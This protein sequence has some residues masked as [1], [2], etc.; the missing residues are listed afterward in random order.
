[1]ALNE[2]VRRLEE[3]V[4]SESTKRA[5]HLL[6]HLVDHL[7][8]AE[9]DLHRAAELLYQARDEAGMRVALQIRIDLA[10]LKGRVKGLANELIEEVGGDLRLART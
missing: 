6:L 5:T 8:E 2:E 9:T 3:H 7:N 4:A 1:V 10:V